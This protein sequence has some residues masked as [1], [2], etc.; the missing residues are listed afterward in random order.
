M[1]YYYFRLLVVVQS[2]SHVQLFVT[3]WTVEHHASLSFTISQS[4]LKPMSI[5]SV[6]TFKRLILCHPLFLLPS[7]FPSIKVFSI[8]SAVHVRW[9]NYW[10][11]SFSISPF[12]SIQ[13]W[14]P[15][16]L[17]RLIS[18]LSKGLSRV[19]SRTQFAKHWFFGAQASLWSN[20]HIHSRW[21]VLC[22]FTQNS[23]SVIWFVIGCTNTKFIA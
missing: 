17:T 15:V 10:S 12:M 23:V 1:N 5:E 4:L 3:P 21:L 18:L 9:P 7:F 19:F 22:Y 11:L 6:M 13:G 8:K 2:L 14:F 20:Y 16:E